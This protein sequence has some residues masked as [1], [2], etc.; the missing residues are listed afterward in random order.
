MGK[1][2]TGIDQKQTALVLSMNA[3]G[4]GLQDRPSTELRGAGEPFQGRQQRTA[5]QSGRIF[6]PAGQR[7]ELLL[8]RDWQ[9][10]KH[11]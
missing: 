1:A 10:Q 7:T 5:Q 9:Q 4:L 11:I 8:T 3:F 6:G 2:G